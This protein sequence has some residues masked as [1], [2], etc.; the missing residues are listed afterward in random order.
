[1]LGR[2]SSSILRPNSSKLSFEEFYEVLLLVSS[3]NLLRK[4]LRVK[5]AKGSSRLESVHNPKSGGSS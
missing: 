3:N 4:P 1:M 5:S 2:P